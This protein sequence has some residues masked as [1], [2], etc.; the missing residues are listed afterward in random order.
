MKKGYWSWWWK[1]NNWFILI[2]AT[3]ALSTFASYFGIL[4]V[5]YLMTH[6]YTLT[7]LLIGLVVLILFLVLWTH[8]SYKDYLKEKGQS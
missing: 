3:F 1:N 7:L 5:A 6:G 4:S 2:V 8:S